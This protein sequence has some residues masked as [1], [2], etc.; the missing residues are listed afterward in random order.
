[1]T[2]I[3]LWPDD[4]GLHPDHCRDVLEGGSYDVPWSPETPPVILDVGANVGAFTRWAAARWPGCTIHAYE[5]H[6]GNFALLKRTIEGLEDDCWFY[7]YPLAVLDKAGT[8][9][10]KFHSEALNCGEWSLN[11][12]GGSKDS[13]EVRVIPATD[14]PR[15]DILKLDTEGA[16]MEILSSLKHRLHEF[17]AVMMEI[18]NAAWVDPICDVL[19]IAGFAVIAKEEKFGSK[20]RVECKFL[21]HGLRQKI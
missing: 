12:S 20:N 11:S 17:S 5:P 1:M 8:R 19:Q 4:Y 7:P 18:H 6:P 2:S 13:V 9:T 21:K 15:A 14:L 10:L 3:K 16:E